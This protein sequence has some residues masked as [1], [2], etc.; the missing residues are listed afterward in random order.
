M[1]KDMHTDTQAHTTHMDAHTHTLTDTHTPMH[2][3]THTRTHTR[4][5]NLLSKIKNPKI[6]G[7]EFLASEQSGSYRWVGWQPVIIATH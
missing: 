2:G 4:T 5:A 6:S 1:K 7:D 3:H